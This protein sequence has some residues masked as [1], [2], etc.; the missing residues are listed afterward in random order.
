M[1]LRVFTYDYFIQRTMT[2][3]RKEYKLPEYSRKEFLKVKKKLNIK[4][5]ITKEAVM[6]PTVLGK[7]EDVIATLFKCFNKITEKTYEKLSIEI[8]SLIS[9]N[10]SDK[11][12][13]CDAFFKLVH[14]NS[15][16]CKL[17]AK[18]YKGFSEIS[19]DFNNIIKTRMLSYVKEIENIVYVSPNED[20]DKYCDYVKEV[21]GVKNFTNFIVQ[22]SKQQIVQSGLLL[23]LLI[24]F[25]TFS[26]N[27]IDKEE[28][29]LFN[30]IYISNI[31][32]IVKDARQIIC[33]CGKWDTFV[34]NHAFIKDTH[35]R[36]KNK[37]IHFRLLDIS[38]QN[39]A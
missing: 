18:L 37:K 34:A 7:Q 19:D 25:Q 39:W 21:E 1:T 15:F 6:K 9:E 13:M 28:K 32:I 16:F 33:G 31:A 2:M 17:Y 36:G 4:P 14:K 27:N 3:D 5:E 20:Y 29:I 11:T 24:E 38:E 30:E 8:F 23:D 12:K 10:I 26:M 22:C 35:G